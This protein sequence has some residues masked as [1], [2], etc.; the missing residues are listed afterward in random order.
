MYAK[1]NSS[2]ITTT[3]SLITSRFN[4]FYDFHIRNNIYAVQATDSK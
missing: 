1:V 3:T 4:N 2:I